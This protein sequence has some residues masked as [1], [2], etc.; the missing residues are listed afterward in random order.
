MLHEIIQLLKRDNLMVQALN[1]CYEMV[2]ICRAMLDASVTSLRQRD[3]ASIDLDIKALDK[4]L[5]AFERDVRR[6]VMT[7]LSIVKAGDLSSGLVLVSIVI[8]LERIGD[9]S[10]NIYDLAVSHPARLD[11]GPLE[12]E[13]KAIERLAEDHFERSMLAFKASDDVAARQ[14]M[15]SYKADISGACA[16]IEARLVRGEIDLPA[17][18]AVTVA[19]YLRFLKRISS[20]ARNLVSA[21]A[22]PF[23][24]I[25]YKSKDGG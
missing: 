2:D 4:K 23:P 8:D 6:K 19:L 1:E 14:L 7:H 25:G 3:D 18:E 10:K 5:N 21:V 24:R 20:H 17:A 15:D 12:A 22:N 11:A 16:R 9:Y 13:V